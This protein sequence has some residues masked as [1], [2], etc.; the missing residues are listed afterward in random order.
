[1]KFKELLDEMSRTDQ[2]YNSSGLGDHKNLFMVTKKKIKI[3]YNET[4]DD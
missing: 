4:S 1:M 3:H 2:E